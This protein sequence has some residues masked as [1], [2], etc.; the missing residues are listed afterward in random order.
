MQI[1]KN[2]VS[3]AD[4]SSLEGNTI[5]LFLILHLI[6]RLFHLLRSI[7]FL[8]LDLFRRTPCLGCCYTF[9]VLSCVA[10][11]YPHT[12]WN[13]TAAPRGKFSENISKKGEELK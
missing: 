8:N 10:T 6:I 3:V 4:I 7:L 11:S 1:R 12:Y 2:L 9:T 5:I 13:E